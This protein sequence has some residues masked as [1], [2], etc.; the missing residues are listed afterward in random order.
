MIA[1]TFFSHTTDSK[2]KLNNT[3]KDENE[4]LKQHYT[5]AKLVQLLEEKGSVTLRFP[6][7]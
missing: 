6:V 1:I 5:E 4:D 3:I 2:V 7:W